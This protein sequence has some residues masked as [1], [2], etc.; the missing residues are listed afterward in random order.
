MALFQ[1]YQ[2][3]QLSTF[4]GG[5]VDRLNGGERVGAAFLDLSKAFGSMN[6]DLL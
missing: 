2:I 6:H 3:I 5:I 1:K 4:I